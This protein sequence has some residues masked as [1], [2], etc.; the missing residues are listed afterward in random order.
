LEGLDAA[1]LVK[2]PSMHPLRLLLLVTALLAPALDARAA[3]NLIPSASRNFRGTLGDLN[4]PFAA[5][6]DFVEIGVSPDR[7]AGASAGLAASIDDQIVTVVFEPPGGGDRRV[8]FLT[9]QGCGAPSMVAKAGACEATVGA[10]RVACVQAGAGVDMALVDRNGEQRLS[11]RFPDTDAL[12]P[13]DG[14]GRT[15]T[16]PATIAVTPATSP[17]PCGLATTSCATQTTLLACVDTIFTADGSCAPVPAPVFS[18]FTALPRPNDFQADCFRDGPPCTG[19]ATET[20]LAVDG[21]GNLLLPVH[22]GGVLIRQNDVPVPRLV[23]A[24]IKSPLPFPVPDATFLASYTPEGAKLPPIFEPQSDPSIADPDVVTLFGSADASY[25]IL[26]F[27]RRAGRC[28]GGARDTEACSIDKDCLGG[29]CPTTCVGGA[30]PDVACTTDAGCNGGRC[31]QLFADYRP[32]AAYGG[33]L[34]L[35]RQAAGTCLLP[36][37]D[38][39]AAPGD[40]PTPGDLCVGAG[41]CQLEPHGPCAAD[42]DCPGGGNACVSYALEATTAIPL[43]SLTAGSPEVF[44][45]TVNESTRLSDESGDGDSV[46]SVVTL[47]DRQTG[48]TQPMGAPTGCGIAPAA[49]GR[50]VVRISDPPFAYPAVETESDVVAFLESESAEGHCDQDH[51]DDRSDALLRVFTL[52]GGERT[53]TLDPPHVADTALVVNDRALAVSNGRVFFRRPER[54][55]APNVTSRVDL[56]PGDAEVAQGVT[57]RS[58]GQVFNVSADG[59]YVQFQSDA[60]DLVAGD[61][62]GLTDAFVR[63]TLTGVTERVSLRSDGGGLFASQVLQSVMSAD[64]RFVAFGS[65]DGFV[66]PGDTNGNADV[67]VR[68]RVLNTTERVSVS[69]TGAGGSGGNP[70]I[71]ACDAFGISADGRFVLFYSQYTNLVPNDTNDEFDLFVR[72]RLL[73]TTERVSVRG[74]GSEIP[75]ASGGVFLGALSDDGRFVAF[76]SGDPDI[77][78]G[79]NTFQGHVYVHDLLTHH[80]VRASVRSDGTEGSGHSGPYD[81]MHLSAEGRFVVFASEAALVPSDTNFA[82]DVYVRDLRTGITE[83]ASVG[84]NGVP[85]PNGVAPNGT[86]GVHTSISGDGRHV[87]WTAPDA[88]LAVP[89]DTNGFVDAFVY[90]RQTQTTERVSVGPGGVQATGGDAVMPVLSFDG[91]TVAFKSAATDLVP[92][93]GNG[94]FDAFRRTVDGSAPA[95]DLFADGAI[96][97]TV[98]EVFD[99]GAQTATVLCPASQVAVSDGRAAFL[100]PE[101]VAGTPACPGGSLN[102]LSDGDTN[103]QVAQLWQGGAVV[104]LALA[105]TRV[106]L[107]AT[108]VAALADEAGEGASPL[109]GDGDADDQ[110]VHVRAIGGGAWTN[111]GE[112]ADAIAVCGAFVP[113][114]TPEA[115]QGADRN[116]DGDQDDRVLQLWNTAGAGSLVDTHRGAEEF[117]CGDTLIAF[118]SPESGSDRNGDGDGTDDTLA[119]YDMTT[120]IVHETG[121]AVVPCGLAECDPRE[122]YRVLPRSVKFLTLEAEQGGTDLNGD[123]DAAD[124]VIQTFDVDTGLTTVIGT[125]RDGVNPLVGGVPGGTGSASVYVS[126]GRCAEP[127]G[128]FCVSDGECATGA[129]CW[130]FGCMRETG[131]C[132]SGDECAPNSQCVASTIVPASPDTDGDGVPDHLDNCPDTAPA[133][134]TDTDHD[135]VGDLC[136][137]ATCH[138]GVVDAA[139]QCD[140]D[141]DAAC[142]GACTDDCRCCPTVADPKAVVQVTTKKDAGTLSLKMSV[143]LADYA[144]EPVAL[145]LFDT[146]SEPI[147]AT[148][149]GTLPPKG[150][151]GVQWAYKVKTLGLQQVTLK[152]DTKKHPGTFKIVA[153]AKR[154]FAAADANQAAGDTRVRLTIGGQCLEH[155]VTKK[156]D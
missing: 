65:L 83:L 56:G 34:P 95:L 97:D 35:R 55:P 85:L 44:S 46:D 131:V 50:A 151:K 69:S 137:V 100:R 126:T 108:H 40:C 98:L 28:V 7:C 96:D 119:V 149:V 136:D 27:A 77:L 72:D 140:G 3:C 150:S 81:S 10:G 32:L 11:F 102:P 147:V 124:L 120:G 23:R 105:A 29:T 71:V 12:F 123:G 130:A 49:E 53:A 88:A 8:A 60:P 54:G 109:N 2:E 106:A 90:D 51:D 103:D 42:G 113:F 84:T 41:I 18:S 145:E 94:T 68:D 129:F 121:Q 22:W 91:S 89:G 127:L 70:S 61:T 76:R 31:G 143:P 47:R 9:T 82:V 38:A 116:G 24:T 117:V 139:E 142:P 64:G 17:L 114:I 26:R 15:A 43:E 33:P 48:K 152:D 14:D 58:E 154:W 153:K 19:L 99:A 20:R 4:R 128:G 111:V 73:N 1:G 67:F 13:P 133:D 74:D 16:G 25:T 66:V 144:G 146:D 138:N 110:V 59:R 6:G 135:G 125:V 101:S 115:A 78:P 122:P 148:N 107:G 57:S 21:D 86:F 141:A 104:N 45:F 156:K 30:T 37:H 155:A 39:C 134:Q 93:D 112:A 75:A 5:P 80:I 92:G 52:G 63:D 132:A 36:P 62:N 79:A 118:R 87:A